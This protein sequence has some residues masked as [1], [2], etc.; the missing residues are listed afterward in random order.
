MIM[1]IIM[2]KIKIGNKDKIS[3]NNE[4]K[5]DFNVKYQYINKIILNEIF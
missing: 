5:G 4:D 3:N 2:K 1:I